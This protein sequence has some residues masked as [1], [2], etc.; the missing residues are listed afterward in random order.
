MRRGLIAAMILC[1]VT[2]LFPK[3]AVA[4][5]MKQV[6]FSESSREIWVDGERKELNSTTYLSGDYIMIPLRSVAE[7]L[8]GT[9]KWEAGPPETIRVSLAGV[10]AELYPGSCIVFIL[11]GEGREAE[12]LPVEVQKKD[13][14]VCVPA[15][16]FRRVFHLP[17]A[18]WQEE[19]AYLLGS[20][21]RPPS[22]YFE[23]REP[24]YAGAP[25]EYVVRAGD[26]EGDAIIEEKWSGKQDVFAYPGNYTVTLQVKDSR[27]SWS[28]P[29][30]R[31]ISVLPAPRR[32]PG[33][34][35]AGEVAESFLYHPFKKTSGP[36]LLFSDSPEYI[37]RPGILYREQVEGAARLYYW[38]AISSPLAFRVYVLAVNSSGEEARLTVVR[39]GYGGPSNDVYRVA[40]EALA[41]YYRSGVER[42]YIVRP[43]EA[44]VVN[45]EAPAAV[46]H[47]VLHGILDVE[48]RGKLWFLFIAV[49]AT[50]V[51]VLKEYSKLPLLPPDGRHVR[52]TFGTSEVGMEISLSAR[53]IGALVLA[54]G[55]EDEFVAGRDS[56]TAAAVVNAGNYGVQYRIKVVGARDTQVFLVPVSGCFGGNIMVNGEIIDLPSKGF[57][58]PPGQP[59]FVGTLKAN[60]VHELRFIPPG[61]SC[62]PVKLIFRP[63]D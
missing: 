41:G 58:E 48:A 26:P 14:V 32:V 37:E 19:K 42:E 8:G 57:V 43:G 13:G 62:L 40:R 20:D 24:V 55:Q 54:D 27:G 35:Y 38:H 31:S 59:I 11:E 23:V 17:Y 44:V 9:V 33:E 56:T 2:V 5:S 16:I 49:P 10:T 36:K 34:I 3:Y 12:I 61:G 47:Q 1:A 6:I 21:N 53:E 29:F 15:I 51:D 45:S 60:Q 63:G 25:V 4:S 7:E 46:R 22:A 52:G 18:K 50:T 30:S 28:K 39:E